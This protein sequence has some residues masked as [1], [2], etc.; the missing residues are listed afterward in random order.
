MADIEISDGNKCYK[1]L[2]YM[3]VVYVKPLDV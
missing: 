2:R 3:C 1:P